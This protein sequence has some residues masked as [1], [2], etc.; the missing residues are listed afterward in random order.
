MLD[1]PEKTFFNKPIPKAKFYEHLDVKPDRE[2][3][4][5][6]QAFSGDFE[7]AAGD[8]GAGN[9]GLRNLPQVK[10]AGRSCAEADR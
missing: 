3:R 7:R 10:S 8:Q 2:D 5:A 6:E 4:L 1:F 9:P